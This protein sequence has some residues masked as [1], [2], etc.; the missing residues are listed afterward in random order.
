[1]K[2]LRRIAIN[3]LL[4]LLTITLV[5]GSMAIVG[6]GG[7][8]TAYNGTFIIVTGITGMVC[9]RRRLEGNPLG[10]P[11]V[12]PGAA[13]YVRCRGGLPAQTQDAELGIAAAAMVGEPD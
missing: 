8:L 7:M 10:P 5:L 6:V 4:Y 2:T 11:F 12:W 1:M 3:A 9:V 13:S